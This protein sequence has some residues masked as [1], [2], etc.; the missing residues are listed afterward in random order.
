MHSWFIKEP[1]SGECD[2]DIGASSSTKE[3]RGL[4]AVKKK[5]GKYQAHFL[6]SGFTCQLVD[7]EERFLQAQDFGDPNDIFR[8]FSN[9]RYWQSE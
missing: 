2:S 8:Q 7:G 1:K 3:S 4:P 9:S 5:L 6:T